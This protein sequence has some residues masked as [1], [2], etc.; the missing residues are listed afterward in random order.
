MRQFLQGASSSPRQKLK[1]CRHVAAALLELHL[2]SISHGD[3]KLDN[4]LIVPASGNKPDHVT[5]SDGTFIVAKLADFGHSVLLKPGEVVNADPSQ[6]YRGTLA[7]NAPELDVN[8]QSDFKIDFRKCDVWS[9]GLLCLETVRKGAYYGAD[10]MI[11]SMIGQGGTSSGSS[12]SPSPFLSTKL[13][14]NNLLAVKRQLSKVAISVCKKV[15]LG[16]SRISFIQTFGHCLSFEAEHRLAD[17]SSLPLSAP[18]VYTELPAKR[19]QLREKIE[20]KQPWPFEILRPIEANTLV[21]V[22]KAQIVSDAEASMEQEPSARTAFQLALAH[23]TGY[24]VPINHSAFLEWAERSS[25]IGLSVATLTLEILSFDDVYNQ[26]GPERR[27]NKIVVKAFRS[28]FCDIERIAG[29]SL[30]AEVFAPRATGSEGSKVRSKERVSSLAVPNR[31]DRKPIAVDD[32]FNDNISSDVNSPNPSTGDTPLLAAAR[33][34]DLTATQRF[35]DHGA[36]PSIAGKDGSVPLHWLFMFPESYHM[37]IG[38]RL[39]PKNKAAGTVH[40]CVTLPQKLDAQLPIELFGTPLSFAVATASYSAVEVLLK[41]DASP[42]ADAGTENATCWHRSPLNLAATLHLNKILEQLLTALSPSE[43]VGSTFLKLL[44]VLSESS[45]IERRLIHGAASSATCRNTVRLIC[46]YLDRLSIEPHDSADH[47]EACISAAI[48]RADFDVAT[49]LAEELEAGIAR[50]S[51]DPN[52]LH[53]FSEVLLLSAVKLH[54]ASVLDTSKSLDI[55]KWALGKIPDFQKFNATRRAFDSQNPIFVAIENQRDDLLEA[56]KENGIDI[57]AKDYDGRSAFYNI[58]IKNI[59]CLSARRMIS[60]GFDVNEGDDY[61]ATPLHHAVVH[62]S[63][64]EIEELVSETADINSRDTQGLT[65]LHLAIHHA[66]LSVILCLLRLGADP[67][68]FDK[69]GMAPI[70]IAAMKPELFPVFKILL[71]YGISGNMQTKDGRDCITLAY[72][73][74]NRLFVEEM[75]RSE[76]TSMNPTASGPDFLN[77]G[78]ELVHRLLIPSVD[79]LSSPHED[80]RTLL[81]YAAENGLET[82]ATLL[83]HII[84]QHNIYIGDPERRT[85]ISWAAANG[86]TGLV[87][88]LTDLAHSVTESEDRAGRRPVSLAAGNGHVE[89][90]RKLLEYGVDLDSRCQYGRTALSWAAGNGHLAT[91]RYLLSVPGSHIDPWDDDINGQSPIYWALQGSHHEI[92]KEL[93]QADLNW[94][95]GPRTWNLLFRA[96][97]RGHMP[98]QI[99]RRRGKAPALPRQAK[100]GTK[101]LDSS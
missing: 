4:V 15:S 36:D 22:A 66:H 73:H 6:K 37:R 42:T 39:G 87:E 86:H 60:L 31:M 21:H 52:R 83:S 46:S 9:F 68:I 101:L 23:A 18:G 56:L 14:W 1:L 10:E 58:Y 20:E 26:Q 17:L 12:S 65:P 7:Y 35:L 59:A 80:G 30:S 48:S 67:A 43:H 77:D 13:D 97:M 99:W 45:T 78:T 27:F 33:I 55:V 91:V 47:M 57:R 62:K 81:S 96:V 74:G 70:H 29:L 25:K 92:A 79:Y 90:V 89:T 85:L 8:Q 84:D 95:Y 69:G 16:S 28:L 64:R 49:A 40:R 61:S 54:C 76:L 24:G 11:M 41:L 72:D 50:S 75:I 44:S 53:F 32:A 34:G 19:P 51:N 38:I 82:L 94:H 100:P 88:I 98:R 63:P 71:Q 3:V 2:C 5:L 93:V